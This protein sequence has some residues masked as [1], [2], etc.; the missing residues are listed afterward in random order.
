MRN[1]V[2]FLTNTPKEETLKFADAVYRETDFEVFVVVDDNEY[3]PKEGNSFSII[4]QD[5]TL[6]EYS[7]YHG[8]NIDGLTTHIKKKIISYDKFLL[9][10]C[11][12]NPMF[13]FVWVFEDDVFIPSVEHIKNIHAKYSKHDLVTSNNIRDEGNVMNWHWKHIVD[14]IEAPYYHAMSCGIGVSKKMLQAIQK[15]VAEK[16]QLF[17]V[18]ALFNTIA[19]HNDLDVCTPLELKSIVWSGEWNLDHFLLLPDNL[20]HPRKDVA[21]YSKLREQINLAKTNK[22]KPNKKVMPTYIKNFLKEQSK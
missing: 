15:Y 13:D 4:Q 19:M 10:F 9:Y 20:F 21:D 16:K 17:H 6:C 12:V 1:A 5:D 18:E 7:G 3:K 11:V 14:K 22:Y 8:T 2:V